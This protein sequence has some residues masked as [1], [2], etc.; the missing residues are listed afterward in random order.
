VADPDAVPVP[1]T[2]SEDL[3]VVDPVRIPGAAALERFWSR[4]PTVA[5]VFLVA[6]VID[7]VARF[8]GIA[9]LPPPIDLA[10]PVTFLAFLPHLAFVL[11]PAV[12]VWRRA[13][14]PTATPLVLWGAITIALVELL[15]VPVLSLVPV[16]GNDL[17]LWLLLQLTAITARAGGY[18]ALAIGVARE[19]RAAPTPT[20][21]GLSNLVLWLIAGS[22]V[23]SMLLTF[24]LP[25]ADFG[26]P[27][28]NGQVQLAN[29]LG[30]LP[31][32]AFAY[33]ARVL[34]RGTVDARRPLQATY[35]A[36]GASVLAAV[37]HAVTLAVGF[38]A[39]VQLSLALPSGALGAS[40]S[41][42]AGLLG[43]AVD[44]LLVAAFGLGLADTSVRITDGPIPAGFQADPVHWPAA[45]GEVPRYRPIERPAEPPASPTADG[46]PATTR[47]R[48]PRIGTSK[49][50]ES[51]G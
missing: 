2:S 38:V 31:T 37:L 18:L 15:T 43:V 4:L 11:F 46:E 17:T 32:I 3:G 6:A 1:A 42:V 35:T 36:T 22:A 16:A 14:A 8:L 9:G 41:L 27:A 30:S 29:A 45:G 25:A 19:T 13:D 34:V 5:R 10:S 50:K 21:L 39:F 33:L 7:V 26:D 24:L 40:T 23:I 51:R 44:V 47:R 49:Q 48:G 20:I 28:W 12:I